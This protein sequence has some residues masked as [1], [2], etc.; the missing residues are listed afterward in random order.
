[1]LWYSNVLKL[2]IISLARAGY[3][4]VIN[5]KIVITASTAEC[6]DTDTHPVCVILSQ[7]HHGPIAMECPAIN[8]NSGN[9]HH[10]L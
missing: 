3:Q 1:M 2:A 8:T 6:C 4:I 10:A 5:I 7:S 9:F